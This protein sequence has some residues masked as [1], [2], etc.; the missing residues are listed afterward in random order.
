MKEIVMSLMKSMLLS[1]KPSQYY[2]LCTYSN[3]RQP[4]SYHTKMADLEYCPFSPEKKED[5]LRKVY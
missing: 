1:K 3:H 4:L 5:N 2:I